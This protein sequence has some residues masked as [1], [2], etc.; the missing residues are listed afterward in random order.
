MESTFSLD[1][2]YHILQ[3][4]RRFV[5][6]RGNLVRILSPIDKKLHS[7]VQLI[8]YKKPR[9][10]I[11]YCCF[12]WT[13][14]QVILAK[15]YTLSYSIDDTGRIVYELSLNKPHYFT[16]LEHMLIE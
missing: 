11:F 16:L 1:I 8:L 10:R 15:K 6:Q 14:C 2:I 3:Y 13:V 9:I 7:R 5:I 4:D 12:L